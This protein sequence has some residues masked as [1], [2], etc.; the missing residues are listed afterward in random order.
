MRLLGQGIDVRQMLS[1]SLYA[2]DVLVVCQAWPDG[3]LQRLG[4]Q[5]RQAA[6]DVIERRAARPTGWGRDR[7]GFGDLVGSPTDTHQS[8]RRWL[9]PSAGFAC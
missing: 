7:C 9:A 6:G 8:A 3:D 2:R 4:E 1:R 5:L